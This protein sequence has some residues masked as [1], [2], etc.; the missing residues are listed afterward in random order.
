MPKI[1]GGGLTD[2]RTNGMAL[3][4]YR[5]IDEQKYTFYTIRDIPQVSLIG[6][7]P[8]MFNSLCG[9]SIATPQLGRLYYR[10]SFIHPEPYFIGCGTDILDL[11][12]L[13]SYISR[14]S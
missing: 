7:I 14:N 5:I 13:Y 11:I 8:P 6:Q 9:R 4:V 3:Y 1:L 10:F 2:G 12:N